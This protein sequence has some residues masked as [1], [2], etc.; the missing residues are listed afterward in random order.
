MFH[1]QPA[2]T[3]TVYIRGWQPQTHVPGIGWGH[4]KKIYV[5]GPCYHYSHFI[6][7]LKESSVEEKYVTLYSFLTFRLK[8][9]TMSALILTVFT[10]LSNRWRSSL[11]KKTHH[12]CLSGL[13]IDRCMKSHSLWKSNIYHAQWW[14][15]VISMI[16]ALQ[17]T[18]KSLKRQVFTRCKRSLKTASQSTVSERRTDL[19]A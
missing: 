17:G 16:N 2:G 1:I 10:V 5:Q 3:H 9:H 19:V 6:F 13:A 14:K 18:F 8:Q 11:T 12:S 4:S 7:F 15:S